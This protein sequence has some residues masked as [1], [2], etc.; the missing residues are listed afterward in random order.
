MRTFRNC[1][2][3]QWEGYCIFIETDNGG[4]W[5]CGNCGHMWKE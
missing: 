3:C 1:P 2:I 4:Y 5:V